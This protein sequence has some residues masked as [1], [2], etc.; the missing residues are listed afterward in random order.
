[1]LPYDGVDLDYSLKG[2]TAV[3]TGGAAGIGYATAKLFHAKGVNIV[4]ADMNPKLNE[5]AAGIGEHCI[6]VVGN[7]C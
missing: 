3:I 4:L 6:G 7:V 5:I 1:M 2:K